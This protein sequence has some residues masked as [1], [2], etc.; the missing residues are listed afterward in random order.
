MVLIILFFNKVFLVTR[1][2][3]APF[4]ARCFLVAVEGGFEPPRG[5]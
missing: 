1:T 5:S 2:K 3:N 4:G